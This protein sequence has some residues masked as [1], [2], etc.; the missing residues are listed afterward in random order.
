MSPN[1]RN[2]L[3]VVAGAVTNALVVAGGEMLT[4]RL[5]PVAANFGEADL[6]ALPPQAFATILGVTLVGAL[7][8]GLVAGRLAATP[9]RVGIIIGGL[10]LVVNTL[11]AFSFWHPGWFRAAALVL[12]GALGWLGARWAGKRPDARGL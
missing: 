11:N 9:R 8:S 1:F 5:F 6:R 12:P 2:M 10:L 7:S 3:A 4:A